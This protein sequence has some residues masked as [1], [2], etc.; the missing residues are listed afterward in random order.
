MNHIKV[1]LETVLEMAKVN[2]LMLV[3]I[4][5]M[6]NG[7]MIRNMVMDSL[8]GLTEMFI[9]VNTIKIKEM[10]KVNIL[11]L[12]VVFISDNGLMVRNMVMDSL[13]GLTE[14]FI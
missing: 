1:R 10:A 9:L 12:M 13:I 5:T 4:F 6:A 7:L 3:V 8:I 2:L 11:T 14:M